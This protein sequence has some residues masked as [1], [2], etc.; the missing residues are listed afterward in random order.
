MSSRGA[1]TLPLDEIASA[2]GDVPCPETLEAFAD[3]L[4]KPYHNVVRRRRGC[5]PFPVG[6][7]GEVIPWY[8]LGCRPL[9]P[10][11]PPSRTLSY[12][13]GD[14]FVQDAGSL[15]ALA[16]C[17]ADDDSLQ[18]KLICDLCSAPG[19]KATALVEAVTP[20]ESRG[21]VSDA[22]ESPNDQSAGGFVLANEVIRS[23]IGPLQV[24]L[25]RTGSDRYAISNLDPDTLANRL[26]STFDV[27]LVD[28]P[29]SGQAMMGRGKQ[30]SSALAEHQ[31]QHSASRQRRILDAAVKLLRNGGQLVYS[32]C[33]FAEAENEA[34]V[35]RLIHKGVARP[36]DIARLH[37]YQTEPGCYR[38]WPHI[39]QC[40][41]SFAASLTIEHPDAIEHPET[42]NTRDVFR[43]RH[44]HRRTMSMKPPA[45][46]SEWY[47]AL[48]TIRLAVRESVVFGFSSDAPN[49]VDQIAVSGPEL[50]Y[51]AGQTWK[52]AYAGALR[53]TGQVNAILDLDADESACRKYMRGE[54][55]PTSAKGWNVV[56]YRG[57]PLGWVKADGRIGKNHL[58]NAARMTGDLGE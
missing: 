3:A 8:S 6:E 54:P 26:A 25:S 34:Q 51:R 2:L 20:S 44:K 28:A 24:N 19:G 30:R 17:G 13:C 52:P 4:A 14:F 50:S 58:P 9:T 12:A 41:G 21:S 18:G 32:T 1:T 56:R 55:I 16:A 46:L 5:D 29:C 42:E 33:T 27:V 15:L 35:R 57:R 10:S 43:K 38:C 31:I 36:R 48:E 39:H 45:E 7:A 40:A 47:S 53:R 37:S 49:W 11:R 22:D 23:R